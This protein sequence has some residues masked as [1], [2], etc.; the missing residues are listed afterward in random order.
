[1][2]SLGKAMQSLASCVSGRMLTELKVDL[3]CCSYYNAS[4]ENSRCGLGFRAECQRFIRPVLS[5]CWGVL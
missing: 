1:M 2:Q 5:L 4:R 3:A